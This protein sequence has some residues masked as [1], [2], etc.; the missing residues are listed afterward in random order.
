MSRKEFTKAA[1]TCRDTFHG[2]DCKTV[3]ESTVVQF[4]E[5]LQLQTLSSHIPTKNPQLSPQ[6]Y[7]MVLMDFLK[8]DLDGLLQLIKTWPSSIY[9]IKGI[10]DA[11]EIYLGS[12]ETTTTANDSKPIL[13]EILAELYE[14]NRQ[15]DKAIYYSLLLNRKDQADRIEKE[16]L[17]SFLKGNVLLV[18]NYALYQTKKRLL[19]ESKSGDPTPVQMTRATSKSKE[20]TLL[21]LHQEYV[22]VDHCVSSLKQTP[23]L[24]H[25][26]LDALFS[27][28]SDPSGPTLV[29]S[30]T[31]TSNVSVHD[32]QVPLYAEY[33]P[34]RLIE[35]LRTASYF[36]YPQVS[37]RIPKHS[38]HHL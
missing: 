20:V 7:E 24:L 14:L 16:N 30:N 21:I 36:S 34:T 9:N 12:S 15:V 22:S 13:Y 1:E 17:F 2:P 6:M 10:I 25:I 35:F 28:S 11:V 23:K 18:M 32:L 4:A 33:D 31:T 29:T 26:Y 38:S 5:F 19:E 3:W 27:A 37:R 8:N